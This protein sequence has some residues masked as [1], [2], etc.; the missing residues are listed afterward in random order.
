LDISVCIE[1]EEAIHHVTS[2]GKERRKVYDD[3]RDYEGFHTHMA[4]AKRR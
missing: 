1:Y 2:H 4:E 3:K